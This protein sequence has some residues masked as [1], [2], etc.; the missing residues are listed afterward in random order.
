MVSI[1]KAHKAK[2]SNIFRAPYGVLAGSQ[3]NIVEFSASEFAFTNTWVP[4]AL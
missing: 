3:S 2:G 1:T 4:N